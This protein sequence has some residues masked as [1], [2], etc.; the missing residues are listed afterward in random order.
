[1]RFLVAALMVAAV[2]GAA[3]AAAAASV[4]DALPD[5]ATVTVIFAGLGLIFGARRAGAGD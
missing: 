2:P 5:A 3:H 4:A 1:M